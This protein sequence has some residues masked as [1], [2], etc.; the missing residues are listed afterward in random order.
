MS[1]YTKAS[2]S[3]LGCFAASVSR[4]S[5]STVALSILY[6]RVFRTRAFGWS[7]TTDSSSF[8]LKQVES[9]VRCHPH[10]GGT[11]FSLL[12]VYF[13]CLKIFRSSDKCDLNGRQS[14]LRGMFLLS[15]HN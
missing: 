12:T 2:S 5:L 4:S 7:C 6:D 15:G 11:C 8:D 3:S 9:L 1:W 14:V 13:G 10:C